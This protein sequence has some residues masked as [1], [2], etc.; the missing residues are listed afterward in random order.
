MG[1]IHVSDTPIWYVLKRIK[2]R[3]VSFENVNT[4]LGNFY[5]T[6]PYFHTQLHI[7]QLAVCQVH[8]ITIARIRRHN[9]AKLKAR[10]YLPDSS[11]VSQIVISC[12]S[13]FNSTMQCEGI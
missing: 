6:T 13:I 5:D 2:N 12:T 4:N 1:Y 8:L 9:K 7:M 10:S 11:H 3:S